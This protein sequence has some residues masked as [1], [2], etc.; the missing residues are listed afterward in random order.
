MT[1]DGVKFD[2]KCKCY[3]CLN[4]I[5]K[6]VSFEVSLDNKSGFVSDGWFASSKTLTDIYAFVG[7]SATVDD[8]TK[9]SD[10]SQIT[11][12]DIV[13]VKK[14]DLVDYIEQNGSSV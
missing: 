1:I 3:G 11:A 14:Q 5:L 7:L 6:Y 8:V 9:L 13:W 12:A 4:D 2:E 10:S